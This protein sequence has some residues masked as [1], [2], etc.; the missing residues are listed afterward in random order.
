MFLFEY[1]KLLGDIIDRKL[2]HL[3]HVVFPTEG[4]GVEN[5]KIIK[6][7]PCHLGTKTTGRKKIKRIAF[8]QD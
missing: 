3:I 4:I 7:L 2:D 1:I 8:C 6:K 5:L